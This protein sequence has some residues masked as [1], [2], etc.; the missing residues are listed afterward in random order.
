MAGISLTITS[1]PNNKTNNN[2]NILINNIMY[3]LSNIRPIRPNGGSSNKRHVY[4]P[5]EEINN[6]IRKV[7]GSDYNSPEQIKARKTYLQHFNRVFAPVIN[8]GRFHNNAIDALYDYAYNVGVNGAARRVMPYI[9]NYLNGK[10]SYEDIVKG[11]YA[12][13]DKKMSGLRNRREYEKSRF[14]NNRFGGAP[15]IQYIAQPDATRVAIPVVQG[16]PT[17]QPINRINPID[18]SNIVLPIKPIR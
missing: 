12:A 16:L 2:N 1:L 3:N 8:S 15:K 9:N 18:K 14:I 6:Y 13:G 17:I 10:G 7:E 11:I 5:S 4:V